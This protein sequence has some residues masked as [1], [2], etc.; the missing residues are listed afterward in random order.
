MKFLKSNIIALLVV[1]ALFMSE[2]FHLLFEGVPFNENVD[3]SHGVFY[4]TF[5][6]FGSGLLV[7]VILFFMVTKEMI[8]SRAIFC[9]VIFWNLIETWE[10]FCYLAKIN[11]NVLIINDGSWMQIFTVLLIT[12]LTWYG[13]T[14]FK[15]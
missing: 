6:F 11:S 5:S 12:L 1:F 4:F 2:Y 10:N 8:A 3:L 9:G 13:F 7:S 14:K 15:S